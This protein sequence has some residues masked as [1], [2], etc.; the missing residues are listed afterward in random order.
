M[1]PAV[2]DE[3][4]A[5]VDDDFDEEEWCRYI[6]SDCYPRLP[7]E[8]QTVVGSQSIYEFLPASQTHTT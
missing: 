3:V 8:L 6:R 2:D 5:D 1:C 4:P 7:R